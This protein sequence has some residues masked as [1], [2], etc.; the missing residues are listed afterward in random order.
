MGI[1]I[2]SA[3]KTRHA[4]IWRH[5]RRILVT[6]RSRRSRSHPKLVN[7]DDGSV[8]DVRRVVAVVVVVVVVPRRVLGNKM[9]W[10]RAARL[11]IVQEITGNVAV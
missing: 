3:R 8:R 9:K 7:K 4:V 6:V 11:P 2:A 10:K 5:N 1:H